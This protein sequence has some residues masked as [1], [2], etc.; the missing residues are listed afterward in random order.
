MEDPELPTPFEQALIQMLGEYKPG[1]CLSP[2]E[3][4]E[5]AESGRHCPGYEARML[6]VATCSGCFALFREVRQMEQARTLTE[7][8]SDAPSRR[9]QWTWF[10]LAAL[11]LAAV[12]GL[13]LYT[14]RRRDAPNPVP[15]TSTGVPKN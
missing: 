3:L 6:H 4:I 8:P 7:E 10:L 5:L 12:C 1:S 14:I 2:E 11:A 13:T 9:R 15:P